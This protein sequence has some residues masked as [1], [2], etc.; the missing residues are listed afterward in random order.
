[1]NILPINLR[2]FEGKKVTVF[3]LSDIQYASGTQSDQCSVRR[4][5]EYLD[6]TKDEFKD[7]VRIFIGTGDYIDCMSPSN[8]MMAAQLYESPR[9]GLQIV[10][11]HWVRQLAD[12]LKPRVADAHYGL[13]MQ[14]HHW[15]PYPMQ[16]DDDSNVTNSDEHL[17]ELLGFDYSST[18]VNL[19][20]FSLTNPKTMGTEQVE[21]LASHG[22]AGGGQ[23]AGSFF[24]MLEKQANRYDNVDAVIFSHANRIGAVPTPRV[25]HDG[26]KWRDRHTHLIASGSFSKSIL[27]KGESYAERRNYA[28]LGIGASALT[29]WINSDG[30]K[31][32]E[33]RI[34]T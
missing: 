14:G 7:H 3:T 26:T 16:D 19:V 8:R 21:I 30:R 34:I 1:M 15:T 5:E 28:P 27:E 18:W 13:L 20:K 31:V 17:A 22:S 24:N 4:L 33:S 10:A 25:R 11:M 6:W 9:E 29:F 23:L 12:I 2:P 32:L